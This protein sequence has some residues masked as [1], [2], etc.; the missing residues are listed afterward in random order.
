MF[1][2]QGG[3]GASLRDQKCEKLYCKLCF[4]SCSSLCQLK[5]ITWSGI[6]EMQTHEAYS[7]LLHSGRSLAE[8]VG[9][10]AW[11]AQL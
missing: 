11:N 4:K 5:P 6:L 8:C 1:M 2:Y 7:D 3:F 10:E 9:G